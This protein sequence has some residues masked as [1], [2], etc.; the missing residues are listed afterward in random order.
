M[1]IKWGREERVGLEG[2]V[3]FFHD[4]TYRDGNNFSSISR[5]I[6]WVL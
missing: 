2:Y 1:S 5:H 4:C 3:F 6:E